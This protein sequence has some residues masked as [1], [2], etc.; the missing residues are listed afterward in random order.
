MLRHRNHLLPSLTLFDRKPP[1]LFFTE[2]VAASDTSSI[3]I[4][5][6]YRFPFG[7]LLDPIP[8]TVPYNRSSQQTRHCSCERGIIVKRFPEGVA[9]TFAVSTVACAPTP[10]I[11]AA[12]SAAGESS[13]RIPPYRSRVERHWPVWHECRCLG[14]DPTAT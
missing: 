3:Q 11:A 2:V 10:E 4:N 7:R 12:L 5:S 13:N 9:S 14:T 8:T 1:T 6:R